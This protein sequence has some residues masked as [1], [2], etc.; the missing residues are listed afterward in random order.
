[1]QPAVKVDAVTKTFR[2]YG[3]PEHRLVELLSLGRSRRHEEFQALKGISLEIAQGETVGIVGR[4]GCGKST[5]LQIIAGVL[6]PTSG[7]F[8][9]R[10][11]IA[12][13]LELG[14]GFNGEFTGRENAYINGAILGMSH[15][16]M[17]DRLEAIIAF[18]DIGEFID[19]PVKTYSSGMFVRLAFA[20]AISVEPDILIIDE[21]LSVGDEA[22]QR[23]CFGR[24]EHLKASGCTI[25]FVSHS[26]QSVVQ[27]C[28][29]A[30]LMD[31]GE[32]LLE[33]PPK[34][35]TT[36]FLRLLHAPAARVDAVRATIRSVGLHA[37]QNDS[38]PTADHGEKTLARSEAFDSEIRSS[39]VVENEPR[40]ATISNVRLLTANGDPVNVVLRWKRYRI[41]YDVH[42]DRS[43]A[44]V[45]FGCFI[46][47]PTGFGLTGASTA[48]DKTL[49]LP[50]V[51][52]GSRISVAFEFMCCLNPGLF[53]CN[54]GVMGD[55]D[56]EY[57]FLHRLQDALAFKVLPD[58]GNVDLGPAN[59][60]F[61]PVIAIEGPSGS[62]GKA[63]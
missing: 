50:S 57:G 24:I 22:F 17:A 55:T 62:G 51:D 34:P 13:L 43:S 8:V 23:K 46:K 28:D 58:E 53:F 14:A 19:R 20:V 12:A 32:L 47:T 48:L 59:F 26:V 40:G 1:M 16:D 2:L 37:G 25:I 39:L 15:A 30:F 35:V 63:A 60:D 44:N 21:A 36:Q 4:N 61:E 18:A 31:G 38:G 5:L 45:S 56:G 11:R 7:S 52:A 33:G 54:T 41:A 3:R 27:L 6:R 42:F 10:G 29:R 49:A 9:T